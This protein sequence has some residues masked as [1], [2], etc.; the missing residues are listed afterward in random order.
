[1]AAPFGS[2]R[3]TAKKKSP[4]KNSTEGGHA[5]LITPLSLLRVNIQRVAGL[6]MA[7]H[8]CTVRVCVCARVPSPWT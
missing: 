6:G 8:A 7:W 1:M 4:T 5:S 3:E 2:G